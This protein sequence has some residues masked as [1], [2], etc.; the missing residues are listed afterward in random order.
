VKLT[1]ELLANA[2]A[3][4]TVVMWTVCS[5]FVLLLPRFSLIVTRWWV[6]GLKVDQLG[7]YNLSLTNFLIGGVTLSLW[8]W[9]TGYVFGWS[10]EYLGKK[11]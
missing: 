11:K 8:M 9:V 1:K 3:L 5:A 10:L 4:T 6:H 7:Q 2:F